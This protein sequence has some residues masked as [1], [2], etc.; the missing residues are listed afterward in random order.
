VAEVLT[1]NKVLMER[2]EMLLKGQVTREESVSVEL[3]DC[4]IDEMYSEV[5]RQAKESKA[6]KKGN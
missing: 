2:V 3:T 1:D 4:V 5:K 6:V